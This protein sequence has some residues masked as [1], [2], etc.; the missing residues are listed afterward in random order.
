MD[1]VVTAGGASDP[2]VFA[3]NMM[4]IA[5]PPSN[6][7]KV[8]SVNDLAKSSVKTGA[9][10]AAGAVRRRSRSRSSPTPRS[11]SS[12]SRSSPT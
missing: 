4:E 5:V 6:P 9:V 3:T 7:A 2:K 12:R 1:Q 11:R 8:A 10:P